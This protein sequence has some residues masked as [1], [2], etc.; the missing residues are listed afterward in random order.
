MGIPET[1]IN[2]LETAIEEDR[3]DP[4]P[5]KGHFG[6]RVA[7]WLGGVLTKAVTEIGKAA[8][9]VVT[10]VATKALKDYYEIS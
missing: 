1:E 2:D 6:K 4:K 9:Q 10:T 5:A 3:K 8:P 7:N